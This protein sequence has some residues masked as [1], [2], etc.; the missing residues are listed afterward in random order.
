MV[1]IPSSIVRLDD[2]KG[3][4]HAVMASVLDWL[5]RLGADGAARNT[6]RSLAERRSAE[7]VVEELVTRLPE[8]AQHR[9]A[10]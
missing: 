4:E 9:P 3:A 8:P 5:I 2:T 6:G 10:A 7:R 1:T